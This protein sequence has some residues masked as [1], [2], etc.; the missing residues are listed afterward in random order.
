MRLAGAA[1]VDRG[2]ALALGVLE[3]ERHAAVALDDAA[4]LHAL[5][6]EA[7]LPTSAALP[8]R[9][10]A[11]PC[12]RCCGCRAA[13]GATGQSKKVMSV[14]GVACAVGVEQVVGAHVVLV[15]GLL[16]QPHA[17]R[18]GVEVVVAPGVGGDGGEM[19][20]AGELHDRVSFLRLGLASAD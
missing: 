20:D 4:V 7:L 16:H 13:R 6:V 18:A 12:G 3:V 15:H 1:V 2:E 19:V 5:L 17:E 11:E 14:P 9:R 8:R 10:R